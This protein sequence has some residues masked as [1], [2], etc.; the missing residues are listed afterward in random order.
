MKNF[1]VIDD[2]EVVRA[3]I[4]TVF[5]EMYPSCH[6]HEAN[7]ETSAVTQIKQQRF[8]LVIMDTLMPDTN[9]FGLLECIHANHHKEKVLVFS[10]CDESIYAK[11]FLKAGA[12]GFVHKSAGL[13]TLRHSITRVLNGRKYVS[14]KLAE[15]LV[16]EIGNGDVDNPFDKLSRREFEIISLLLGGKAVGKISALLAINTNTVTTH[17]TRAYNKLGVKNLLELLELGKLL[18]FS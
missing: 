11:R 14:E 9:S 12:M 5:R 8:D 16:S 3:G 17:K 18:R 2:H 6:I 13:T 4:K 1:L 7:D 10:M 15:Q